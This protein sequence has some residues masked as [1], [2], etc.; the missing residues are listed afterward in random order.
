MFHQSIFFLFQ[1]AHNKIQKTRS[2]AINYGIKEFTK[3]KFKICR[4][5]ALVQKIWI[6]GGFGKPFWD[7][8]GEGRIE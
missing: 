3:W 5:F 1:S 7:G 8:G 6:E 4:L 2:T